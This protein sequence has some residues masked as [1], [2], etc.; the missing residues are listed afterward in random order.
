[1]IRGYFLLI[2]GRYRVTTKGFEVFFLELELELEGG[3]REKGRKI[4]N[5]R[6]YEAAWSSDMSYHMPRL[7]MSWFSGMVG[8]KK[9]YLQ[10]MSDKTREKKK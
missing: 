7:S 10:R 3:G 8:G 4:K 5:E 9:A 6:Y 1:M 2:L